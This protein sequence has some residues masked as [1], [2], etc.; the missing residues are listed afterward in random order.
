MNFSSS[1][2]DFRQSLENYGNIFFENNFNY[3]F[4]EI[5]QNKW[6]N[7]HSSEKMAL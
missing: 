3:F 7:L 5:L 4:F 2:S 1:A 6:K